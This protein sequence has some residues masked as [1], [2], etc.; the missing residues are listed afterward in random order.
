MCQVN[1]II[2][3]CDPVLKTN[4]KLATA[5]IGRQNDTS[6]NNGQEQMGDNLF[7]LPRINRSV[8]QLGAVT[9]M[10]IANCGT[11]QRTQYVKLNWRRG[12]NVS[13]PSM[14]N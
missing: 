12:T 11:K 7:F 14:L 6:L 10:F 5:P 13:L 4:Y 1:I 8:F 3:T 2:N 9:A